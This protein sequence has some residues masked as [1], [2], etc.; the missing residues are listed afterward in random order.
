M[1]QNCSESGFPF[2]PAGASKSVL[3]SIL[4]KFG[5]TI[6]IKPIARSSH[7]AHSVVHCDQLVE[8]IRQDLQVEGISAVGFR[9]RRIVVHLH[10]N[11]VHS[12]RHGRARQQRN[13]LRLASALL[14]PRL[15]RSTSPLTAS[16][17]E[18]V[19]SKTT[20][21]NSRMIASDRMS[22]TRLL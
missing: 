21:A 18:W 14:A 16:C 1:A 4:R 3:Q 5:R 6:P 7:I 13:E 17:T 15:R 10:E 20:G 9:L 12:R 2:G 22:T 8:H 19:A 11:T